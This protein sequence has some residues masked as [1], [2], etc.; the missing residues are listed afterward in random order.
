VGDYLSLPRPFYVSKQAFP[1]SL[2]RLELYMLKNLFSFL[3]CVRSLCL[4]NSLQRLHF[5]YI[6]IIFVGLGFFVGIWNFLLADL[7]NALHLSPL[8]L[9]IALACFSSAGIVLLTFGGLLAD[10]L[11]RRHIL[12]MGIGGAAILLLVLAFVSRY[13]MLLSV[14][15]CGGAFISCYDLAV[16]TLGGDYERYYEKKEMT[17]FHAGFNGGAA[18]GSIMSALMLVSGSQFRTIYALA[19]AL[20]L[21]L[22]VAALILPFPSSKLLTG[23]EEHS[24]SASSL[25]TPLLTS[26]VLCAMLLVSFSFFTD[27]TLDGYTS[28]YLRNL[29]GSGVLLGGLGVAAF[30]LVGLVGRLASTA[31]LRRYGGR[32]VLTVAGLLSASGLLLALLTTSASFAVLGLLLV[33]LGQSPTVPMAFSLAA[34]TGSQ[35]GARAVSVVTACGYTIF[36]ITPLLIGTVASFSS[37]RVAL[38]LTV[39]A[40]L[41]VVVV[42][43]RIPTS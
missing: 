23:S 27:G 12:L 8:L 43:R 36:L 15:L 20:L 30:Q 16:N 41:G 10:R 7:S 29:L 35:Q 28:V 24:E 22:L 9:G 26:L 21:I 18:L 11:A 37:L 32:S 31:L 19:G 13:W 42:A 33:G 1:V 6:V 40:S 3:P 38:L 5:W 4:R 17:N 34:Q 14:L 39:G 25:A 2:S